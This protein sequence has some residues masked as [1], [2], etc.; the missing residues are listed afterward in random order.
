GDEIES[1][2]SRGGDR[3]REALA[4]ALAD[5]DEGVRFRALEQTQMVQGLALSTDEL[6]TVLLQDA[7][8]TVRLKALDVLSTD[9]RVD[10]RTMVAIAGRAGSDPSEQVRTKVQELTQRIEAESHL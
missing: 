7:S 3:A 2:A 6:Q 10:A 5:A 8:E 4:H 1:I 9:P